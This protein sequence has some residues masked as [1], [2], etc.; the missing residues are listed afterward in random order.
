[1][2]RITLFIL[3]LVIHFS[4]TKA[5]SP[6]TIASLPAFSSLRSCASVCFWNGEP[7]RGGDVLGVIL[8][9]CGG[10]VV[11]K[12][13][14]DN[15]CFCRAD[16]MAK[17]TNWLSTCVN[18]KCSSQSVDVASA[19]AL[20]NGYC[21]DQRGASPTSTTADNPIPTAST[22][23]DITG[24]TPKQT[25]APGVPSGVATV[26]VTVSSANRQYIWSSVALAGTVVSFYDLVFD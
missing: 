10:S 5:A 4:S 25:L 17:A 20:Y 1:M 22:R 12:D 11:C 14:A 6:Q 23:V 2:S 24:A 21:I 15:S 26:T 13:G 18:T 7:H 16:L 9:C 3:L 8:D 19:I